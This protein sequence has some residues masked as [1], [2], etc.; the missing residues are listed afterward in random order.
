MKVEAI[1][2][3]LLTDA[4]AG[5]KS[6]ADGSSQEGKLGKACDQFEGMLVRQIMSEGMKPLLAKPLGGSGEGGGVYDYMV[7]DTL[8]N[9]VAGKNGMGIS[10][11]LQAQLS[12]HKPST[13]LTPHS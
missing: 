7:T 3:A 6:T 9:S 10:H 13:G 2:P 11:L 12:P 8:A 1:S 5:M 4:T